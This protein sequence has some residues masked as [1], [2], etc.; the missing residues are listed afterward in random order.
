MGVPQAAMAEEAMSAPRLAEVSLPDIQQPH[1][2]NACVRHKPQP[3]VLT[4]TWGKRPCRMRWM[5]C[6]SSFDSWISVSL[7]SS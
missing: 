1:Q 6:S 3:G 5:S 2:G 7:Y 4:S